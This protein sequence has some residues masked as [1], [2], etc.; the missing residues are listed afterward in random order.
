MDKGSLL[1]VPPRSKAPRFGGRYDIRELTIR[2]V[3]LMAKRGVT[4]KQAYSHLGIDK[5]TWSI[6]VN[7]SGTSGFTLWEFGELAD[8]LEA[9]VGWPFIPEELGELLGAMKKGAR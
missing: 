4:A 5:S 8:F 9:P 2:V 3:R 1:R 7:L 6:K